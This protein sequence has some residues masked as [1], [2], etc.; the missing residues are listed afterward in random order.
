MDEFTVKDKD[1]KRHRVKSHDVYL[2]SFLMIDLQSGAIRVVD[3]KELIGCYTFT[4][5]VSTKVEMLEEDKVEPKQNSD[6]LPKTYEDQTA[7][8]EAISDE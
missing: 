7:E 2:T 1:G 4:N 6:D 3:R 8:E 5:N